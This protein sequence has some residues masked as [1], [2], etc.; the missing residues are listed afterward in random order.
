MYFENRILLKPML[1]R[2]RA[3]SASQTTLLF[4]K[5]L[6]KTE[7]PIFGLLCV[8]CFQMQPFRFAFYFT[9]PGVKCHMAALKR[10]PDF[11]IMQVISLFHLRSISPFWPRKLHCRVW[12]EL[13]K[14]SLRFSLF[15]VFFVFKRNPLDVHS[16]QQ[17]PLQNITKR[18]YIILTPL[19]PT[20][21]L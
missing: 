16:Q 15:C 6:N 8:L 12:R 14:P 20:F 11:I 1:E 10:L 17:P 2:V 3:Y 4:M 7:S 21:I 9:A 19:N 18:T 5:R 13:L